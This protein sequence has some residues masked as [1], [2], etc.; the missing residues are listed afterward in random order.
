MKNPSWEKCRNIL[1]IRPDNMGDLLM[2][3]PAIAALKNNNKNLKITVLTSQKGAKIAPFIK[4][5]D[6]VI[7]ADLPWIKTDKLIFPHVV[8]SLIKKIK[9]YK[10]DGAIVFNVYSQNPLASIMLAYLAGIPRRLAYCRENPYQLLTDWVPDPEPLETINHEVLRQLNLVGTIG[11]KNS[12]DNLSIEIP[13]NSTSLFKKLREKKVDAKKP[14]FIIHP[15]VSEEKRRYSVINFAA[16]GKK[17][18]EKLNYQLLITGTVEEKKLGETIVDYA[19]QDTFNLSGELTFGEL[20]KLISLSKFIISNNTGP[21]HIAAACQTPVVVLYALTNLQHTPWKVPSKTLFFE[22]QEKLKSKNIFSYRSDSIKP[23]VK[24]DEIIEAV[25]NLTNKKNYGKKNET[26]K[27]R[28][29]R[30]QIFQ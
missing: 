23:M 14:F 13:K 3:Q 20:I 9:K 10:F 21:V 16:A 4:E 6:E 19:G 27:E 15:G 7:V 5:V 18:K 26:A 2:T 24:P 8:L 22:V 28:S 25:I 1:C 29:Q 11:A 30:T 17:I 12:S